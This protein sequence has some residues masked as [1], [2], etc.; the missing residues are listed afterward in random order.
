MTFGKHCKRYTSRN[1]NCCR[2]RD[3]QFPVSEGS[4]MGKSQV[5]SLH[6][7]R[8]FDVLSLLDLIRFS[9]TKENSFVFKSFVFQFVNSY[10]TLFYYAFFKQNFSKVRE[11]LISFFVTKG[12]TQIILVKYCVSPGVINL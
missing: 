3:I 12:V 4:R 9:T 11:L 6:Y 7:D 10:I 8:I 2:K 1:C 5:I